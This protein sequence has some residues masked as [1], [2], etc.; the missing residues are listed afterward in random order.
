MRVHIVIANE[1]MGDPT[2]AMLLLVEDSGGL[3]VVPAKI[4]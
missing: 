4:V 3:L 2:N 1:N